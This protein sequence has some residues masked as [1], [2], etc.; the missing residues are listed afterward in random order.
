MKYNYELA[1]VVRVFLKDLVKKHNISHE[2]FKALYNINI[3]R[4]AELGGHK[5]VC[6]CCGNVRYNYNSCGNRHCPKC[7]A[8]KQALW[9]DKL[10]NSTL[11]VNHF[12]MVFTAPHCLNKICLFNNSIFYKIFFSAVKRT[13]H[14]FGYSHYGVETGAVCILHT[15]GQNLSLHPHIHCIV[16]AAGYSIKG[17]WV[18]IGKNNKFLYPVHQ[19]SNVFKGKFMHSL[20]VAM[21]KYNYPE[22]LWGL[23]DDAYKNK[24]VVFS[25]GS[26][27]KPENVIRYLGNY[28][29]RVAI[30]N[31]RIIKVDSKNV[32]FFA[33]DYKK[34]GIR[35]V[36]KING[37]EFLHRFCLHILPRRFVKIRRFGIYN[38][39]TQINLNL[40]FSG[41]I[42]EAKSSVKNKTAAEIIKTI[43]NVDVFKCP[44][45]KKGK[46]HTV[47]EIPRIRSPDNYSFLSKYI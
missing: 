44:V 22:N 27:A 26:M 1:D 42:N 25:K 33:K 6:D 14:S 46:M 11:N 32:Y 34:N 39:T 16:P 13:L 30:T 43:T 12:H 17:E 19:L 18:K 47:C 36:I 9:T 35:K 7:Q 29:H 40:K 41:F 15:W 21:K 24:W 28:T 2:Q 8:A 38:H 31:Q 5:Q 4:T 37:V 10:I 3:C 20:K 23:L 45:C